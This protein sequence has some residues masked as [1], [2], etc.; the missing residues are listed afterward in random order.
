MG[1][2]AGA[3][4][5]GKKE[6][7]NNDIVPAVTF[8]T[9]EVASVGLSEAEAAKKFSKAMVAY[10]PLTEHDRAIAVG[11]T[12]GYIKLISAERKILGGAGGGQLVGATVVAPTAGE[13]I[14]EL[15]LVMQTKAFVGR[16]AQTNHAYPSWSYGLAK[17][18]AQFFTT[19][20]GRK[21][22]PADPD[23]E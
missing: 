13:L 9:P 7:Y 23:A 20:E 14:S 1:R 16:I 3:N 17:T 2:V 11:D 21:A 8:M 4:A 19:I 18:A 12:T 22:R 15:A 10:M 6:K 5:L